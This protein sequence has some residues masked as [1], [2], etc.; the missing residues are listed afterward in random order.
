MR[1]RTAWLW[2]VP[3]AGVALALT[4][5]VARAPRPGPASGTAVS[6]YEVAAQSRASGLTGWALVD[7]ATARVTRRFTHYSAWHLWDTPQR[8]Y[9]HGHGQS[10]QYNLALADV[11]R[12][13]GFEVEVVH[14]ARVR[15]GHNP[16]FHTGHLWLRVTHDGRVRD[17]CAG[18]PDNRAG[19][20]HFVAISQ[21]RPARRLTPTFVAAALTP[22]VVREVWRQVLHRRPVQ[23]WLYRRFGERP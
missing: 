11:L 19:A 18:S 21:V 13:L 23:A 15:A 20:V 14:A 5:M 3:L 12:Q 1:A 16:W 8:A 6:L 22:F 2:G 9:A 10:T 17:V 7:D 4:P